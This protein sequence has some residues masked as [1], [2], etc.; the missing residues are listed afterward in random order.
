VTDTLKNDEC[1]S[2]IPIILLTAKADAQSKL[3]GLRRGADDYL[4][5]PFD[6]EELLV[7]IEKLIELR[8]RLRER[9][10][11]QLF[12]PA[13]QPA[14]TP[15]QAAAPEDV[16]IQ[17]IKS[18]LSE[19]ISDED[20]ALPELCRKIGMSRSQL[21]RK[22]KALSDESPSGF[23]RSYRLHH[24]R[25]LLLTTNLSVSEIGYEVGFKDPAHFS[26]TF[27]EAFGMPPSASRG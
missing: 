2:H 1:T 26:K 8:K 11:E 18:I 14:G 9:F 3:E 21:F 12:P 17:K 6:R 16:F 22:L 27:H 15:A 13:D 10:R 24:A 19:N 25:N 20:F 5:K 4:A 7:R 23:I